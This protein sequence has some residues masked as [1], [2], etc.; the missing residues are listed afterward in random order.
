MINWE[1]TKNNVLQLVLIFIN[2][3]STALWKIYFSY[4]LYWIL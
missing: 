3:C 2:N 4:K 1:I